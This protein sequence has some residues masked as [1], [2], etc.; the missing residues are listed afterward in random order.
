MGVKTTD[1]REGGGRHR[2]GDL[3]RALDRRLLRLQPEVH[4]TRDVL[5]NDDR[6][7]DEGADRYAEREQRHHVERE[8]RLPMRRKVATTDMGIESAATMVCC[9]LCKRA[10]GEVP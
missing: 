1:V 5:E 4:V 7:R 9:Q 8:S 3:G 2:D 6:V 10:A